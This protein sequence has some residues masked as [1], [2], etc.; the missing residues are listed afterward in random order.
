MV[1]G[2]CYCPLA[3]KDELADLGFAGEGFFCDRAYLS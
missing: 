2:I 3:K 1:Y